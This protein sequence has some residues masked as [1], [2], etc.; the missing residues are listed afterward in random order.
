MV[1]KYSWYKVWFQVPA[2]TTSGP[3]VIAVK[4]IL[5]GEFEF[6]EDCQLVCF[7]F[8]FLSQMEGSV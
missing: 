1:S 7:I 2:G 4:A 5:S 3:C 8:G 6:P